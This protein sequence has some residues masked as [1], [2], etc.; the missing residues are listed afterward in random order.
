MW[1]L[2]GRENFGSEDYT[3]AD[4]RLHISSSDNGQ[5]GEGQLMNDTSIFHNGTPANLKLAPTYARRVLERGPGKDLIWAGDTKWEAAEQ[6]GKTPFF[7]S[8][9]DYAKDLRAAGKEYSIVP[10]FKISDHMDHYVNTKNG[11]FFADNNG[12]LSV[13]GSAYADSSESGFY[14]TYAHTDFMKHFELIQDDHGIG[15]TTAITLAGQS[16]AKNIK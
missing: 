3:A 16:R 8:Y 5:L 4:Q 15:R 12:Y 10:E 2:D 9:D 7:K 14:K 13:T 6:A 1:P 11:D